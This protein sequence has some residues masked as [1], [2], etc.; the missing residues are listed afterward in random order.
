MEQNSLS[1]ETVQYVRYSVN[2]Q[3]ALVPL[4]LEEGLLFSFFASIDYIE[5]LNLEKVGTKA[6]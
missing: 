6:P 2:L 5:S 3:K 1:D 4:V